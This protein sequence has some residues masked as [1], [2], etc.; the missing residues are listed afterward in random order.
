MKVY[1]IIQDSPQS[2][3]NGEKRKQLVKRILNDIEKGGSDGV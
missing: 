3:Q 1:L 2:T